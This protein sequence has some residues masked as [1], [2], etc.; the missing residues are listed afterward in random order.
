MLNNAKWIWLNRYPQKN[1]VLAARG[2]FTYTSG[3]ASL[4]I[5]ADTLYQLYVN[6]VFVGHGPLRSF[7]ENTRLDTYDIT[8]YL[9]RGKN[10]IAVQVMY[11]GCSTFKN[12]AIRGGLIAEVV[13]GG[14]VL[15]ATGKEWKMTRNEA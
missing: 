4:V 3:E 8:E 7:P 14:K 9:R 6:G 15:C 13:C 2:C 1:L 11:H 10:T 5:G 12:I